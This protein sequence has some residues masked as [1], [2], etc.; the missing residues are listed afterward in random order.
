MSPGH[1]KG[2]PRARGSSSSLTWN[3]LGDTC[4]EGVSRETYL[5]REIHAEA[6]STTPQAGILDLIKWRK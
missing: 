3:C 1:L 6:H 2:E 4:S 5:R